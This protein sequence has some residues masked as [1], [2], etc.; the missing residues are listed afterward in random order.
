[1]YYIVQS[2]LNFT[3]C[4]FDTNCWN[5]KK[6]I[7]WKHMI[8]FYFN[9]KRKFVKHL[10]FFLEK[11]QISFVSVTQLSQIYFQWISHY[12]Y[13]Y[14]VFLFFTSFSNKRIT[15]DKYQLLNVRTEKSNRKKINRIFLI[16]Y[17]DMRE[18]NY[19]KLSPCDRIFSLFLTLILNYFSIFFAIKISILIKIIIK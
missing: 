10:W 3:E 6:K 8:I 1:M 18:E 15:A 11:Y 4:R 19:K 12:S 17:F 16:F 13:F 14:F 5:V 2:R 9:N 7:N